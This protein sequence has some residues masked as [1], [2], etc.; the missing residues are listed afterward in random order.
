MRILIIGNIFRFPLLLYD[1]CLY[2][3]ILLTLASAGALLF[4][5][6]KNKKTH[7]SGVWLIAFIAGLLM[8][9]PVVLA[10]RYGLGEQ[11]A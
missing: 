2:G 4:G 10:M 1:I 5:A 6:I 3:G 7:R 9:V 11:M 8:L